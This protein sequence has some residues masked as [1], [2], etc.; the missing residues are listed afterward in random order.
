MGKYCSQCDFS[1]A[2]GEHLFSSYLTHDEGERV[3]VGGSR[4]SKS[5]MPMSHDEG[6]DTKPDEP[7]E[8]IPELVTWTCKKGHTWKTYGEVAFMTFIDPL[9]SEEISTGPICV[10]CYFKNLSDYFSAERK[11][12]EHGY[13]P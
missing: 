3:L 8:E 13:R 2:R 5:E 7:T 10:K 12:N 9:S 1:H 4:V 11:D 6:E